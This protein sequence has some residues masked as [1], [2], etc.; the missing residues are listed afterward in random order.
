M[1]FYSFLHLLL[2]FLFLVRLSWLFAS[3]FSSLSLD[4]HITIRF[5][6]VRMFTANALSLGARNP[7]ILYLIILVALSFPPVLSLPIFLLF[8]HSFILPFFF[9][10]LRIISRILEI[11]C[12]LCGFQSFMELI[13]YCVSLN[14]SYMN[15]WLAPYY[16][17]IY[18]P[19]PK[20]AGIAKSCEERRGPNETPPLI[21]THGSSVVSS[22][23]PQKSSAFSTLFGGRLLI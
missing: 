23:E 7:R 16:F 12:M 1:N 20:K 11:L 3:L 9:S 10:A 5:G 21:P 6:N 19:P 18:S 14:V 13:T 22:I 2:L 4:L 8:Y 15:F 17:W